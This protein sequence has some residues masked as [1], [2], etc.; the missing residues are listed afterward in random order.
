LGLVLVE[1]DHRGSDY[2]RVC[3]SDAGWRVLQGAQPCIQSRIGERIA[4]E[5]EKVAAGRQSNCEQ[6]AA[7]ILAMVSA[8]LQSSSRRAAVAEGGLRE[9]EAIE[10]PAARDA[11]SVI[12]VMAI[13]ARARIIAR[14][15]LQ[16]L[17]G[18]EQY[19]SCT[20]I[21]GQLD[22]AGPNS[23]EPSGWLPISTAPKDGTEFFAI[24]N[25]ERRSVS[26]GK[27]S[28]VPIYGFCL[29]DQGVEDYDICEPTM[30][31]P[32]PALPEADQ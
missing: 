11:M 31:H 27:T 12:Q 17:E 1:G 29:A 3:L 23:A 5:V 2:D 25:G 4:D 10:Y 19:S 6:A 24:V 7:D 18:G 15:T 20:D 14:S 30:W 13:V 22:G 28:H 32:Y 9:I 16:S 26:W 8:A 21:A